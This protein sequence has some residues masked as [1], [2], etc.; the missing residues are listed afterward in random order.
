MHFV[1]FGFFSCFLI[2]FL[3]NFTYDTCTICTILRFFTV[4]ILEFKIFFSH[5]YSYFIIKKACF[6]RIQK[7]NKHR[8]HNNHIFTQFRTIQFF[9]ILYTLLKNIQKALSTV[10]NKVQIVPTYLNISRSKQ[11][12]QVLLQL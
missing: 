10:K 7:S 3:Y 2:V 12:L 9:L 4:S 1:H 5:F 8:S 6:I 11:P